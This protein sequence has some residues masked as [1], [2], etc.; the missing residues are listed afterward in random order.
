MPIRDW[1]RP[2]LSDWG[3]GFRYGAATIALA[4][5]LSGLGVVWSGQH[6][7]YWNQSQSLPGYLYYAAPG[8]SL[9]R[10]GEVAFRPPPTGLVLAHFGKD[11]VTFVKLV[12]G[13]PGDMIARDSAG[14][15]LINGRFVG[16]LKPRTH[17]GEVLQPGPLGVIPKGCIYA[18]STR[19][20]GFDSRYAA[21]GLVCAPQLIGPARRL[22]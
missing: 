1:C 22:L 9:V 7:L 19:P 17:W 18:G 15:V 2:N 21:I 11:P 16:Q 3:R 13:V 8:M 5:L 6:R 4:G 20:D 12:L 10:G 14:Q